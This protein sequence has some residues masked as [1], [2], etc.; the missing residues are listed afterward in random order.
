MCQVWPKRKQKCWGEGVVWNF[1]SQSIVLNG[2]TKFTIFT[3]GL[4]IEAH[5]SE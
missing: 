5:K 4:E 1:V 3:S 2:K